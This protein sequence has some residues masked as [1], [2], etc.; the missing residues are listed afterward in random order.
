M[1]SFNKKGFVMILCMILSDTFQT[2]PVYSVLW[3]DEQ[4]LVSRPRRHNSSSWP[5]EISQCWHWTKHTVQTLHHDSY[6]HKSLV[7]NSSAADKSVCVWGVT[8]VWIGP[9]GEGGGRK[10]PHQISELLLT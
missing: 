4:H 9:A 2:L 1:K 8:D 7:P 6:N 10:H 3:V 5:A